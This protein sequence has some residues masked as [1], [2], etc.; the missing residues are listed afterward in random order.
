MTL[1]FKASTP[2][3]TLFHDDRSYNKN[4]KQCSIVTLS[5]GDS[6]V[7]IEDNQVEI[8]RNL[9]AACV[10]QTTNKQSLF[11]LERFRQRR[12]LK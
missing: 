1:R 2:D 12:V 11:S 10:R 8:G 4:W 6:P 3:F 5:S 9:S 7:H